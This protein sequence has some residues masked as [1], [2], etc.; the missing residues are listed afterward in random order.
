MLPRLTDM[1]GRMAEKMQQDLVDPSSG[2][3]DTDMDN[4]DMTGF[5]DTGTS[6]RNKRNTQ[7]II[8]RLPNMSRA[9]MSEMVDM[10]TLDGTLESMGMTREEFLAAFP[11]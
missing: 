9:D 6:A 4:V 8:K 5:S 11:E 7:A 2:M 3:Q 10:G 1:A